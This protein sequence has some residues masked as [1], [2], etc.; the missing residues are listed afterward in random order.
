MEGGALTETLLSMKPL[1]T[2][3]LSLCDHFARF[4]VTVMIQTVKCNHRLALVK[5]EQ[6]RSVV[7][8]WVKQILTELM[9]E[10]YSK[11]PIKTVSKV[12]LMRFSWNTN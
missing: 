12:L 8:I 4:C 6:T 10:I 9:A 1:L 3:S 7:I 2:P 11:S 5:K